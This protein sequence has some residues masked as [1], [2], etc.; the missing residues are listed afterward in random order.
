MLKYAYFPQTYIRYN[1]LKNSLSDVV[2][3]LQSLLF[4]RPTRPTS[5]PTY[6]AVYIVIGA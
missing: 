1:S 4:S 2:A 3:R 5:G 6:V